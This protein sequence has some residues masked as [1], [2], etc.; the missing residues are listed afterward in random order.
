MERVR[1]RRKTPRGAARRGAAGLLARAIR[2]AVRARA[3][4]SAD[5]TCTSRD[6]TGGTTSARRV[7]LTLA[8][9]PWPR[10][11]A[12]GGGTPAAKEY[13]GASERRA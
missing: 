4:G 3:D 7:H 5:R 6:T 13:W 12:R 8:P 1:H 10:N 2:S 11:Q 9:K